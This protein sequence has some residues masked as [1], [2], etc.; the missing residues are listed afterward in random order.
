MITEADLV[1]LALKDGDVLVIRHPPMGMDTFDLMK[2]ILREWIT[3]IERNQE[4]KVT[5]LLLPFAYSLDI[6]RSGELVQV[7]GLECKDAET[8]REP[9]NESLGRSTSESSERTGQD[10]D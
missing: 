7:P 6:L 9:S 8:Q 2:S 5:L 1:K 10:G 3:Q 4:F